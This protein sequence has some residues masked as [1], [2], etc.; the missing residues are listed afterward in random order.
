M[1]DAT[2]RTNR[3]GM[4]LVHIVGQAATNKTFSIGFCFISKENE[5][6]YKWCMLALR[7]L[8]WMAERTPRVFVTDRETALRKAISDV[9]PQAA[10]NVCA[11]HISK[12]ITTHC[13]RHFAGDSDLWFEFMRWWATLCGSRSVEQYEANLASLLFILEPKPVVLEYLE[14]NIFPHKELFMIPWAGHTLHLGNINSSR[15]ESTHSFIK[16]TH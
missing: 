6:A 13:K 11:W 5:E 16:G 7:D 1:I 3:Y 14:A 12:N 2:Y 9:F 10:R 4:P 8:V 15:V